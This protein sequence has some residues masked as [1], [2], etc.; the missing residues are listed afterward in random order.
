MRPSQ[1]LQTR[2]QNLPVRE[3]YI[4]QPVIRETTV[5]IPFPEFDWQFFWNN[6][7]QI[8]AIFSPKF[9]ILVFLYN[10]FA[11]LPPFVYYG[12]IELVGGF[13]PIFPD[14]TSNIAYKFWKVNRFDSYFIFTCK[15][16]DFCR[17]SYDLLQTARMSGL[18]TVYV[19]IFFLQ[20]WCNCLVIQKLCVTLRRWLRAGLCPGPF[21]R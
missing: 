11:N 13:Y 15:D 20:N 3:I 19:K 7:K 16:I 14:N 17:I 9:T 10:T 1:I 21:M 6:V 4:K 5:T 12:Y 18:Q 8:W 2:L